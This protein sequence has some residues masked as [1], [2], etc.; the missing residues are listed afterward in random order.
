MNTAISWGTYIW[1]LIIETSEG[2][3]ESVKRR[4]FGSSNSSSEIRNLQANE[5]FRILP[6][7]TAH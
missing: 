2:M 6:P 3:L 5:R 7:T 4:F 1:L